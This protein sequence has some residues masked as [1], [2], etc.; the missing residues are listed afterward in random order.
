MEPSVIDCGAR[1]LKPHVQS[2]SIGTYLTT[3][4]HTQKDVTYCPRHVHIACLSGWLSACPHT[5][6]QFWIG[7]C[8]KIYTYEAY[9]TTGKGEG[10]VSWTYLHISLMDSFVT[11]SDCLIHIRK[12]TLP[13]SSHCDHVLLKNQSFSQGCIGC[14]GKCYIYEFIMCAYLYADF[15]VGCPYWCSQPLPQIGK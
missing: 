8:N 2:N 15:G 1:N 7:S 6:S 12:R 11:Q 3:P 10:F 14:L 13:S 4:P 5:Q 9:S